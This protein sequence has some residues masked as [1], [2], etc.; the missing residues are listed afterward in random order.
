MDIIS[1]IKSQFPLANASALF[2]ELFKPVLYTNRSGFGANQPTKEQKYNGMHYDVQFYL[3]NS[4][5]FSQTVLTSNLTSNL[6]PINP[7]AIMNLT[8]S[9]NLCNW[10]VGG[11][12][13]LM[14][15]P[16]DAPPKTNT[17]NSRS[18][19]ANKDPLAAYQFR[20]DGLDLLRVMIKPKPLQQSP[21][22][23]SI[24]PNDNRWTLSYMF[25]VFDT[26]DLNHAIPEME[27]AISRFMRCIKLHFR[28]M[29]YDL[30]K[31]TNLEYSTA[32]SPT[33]ETD[34]SLSNGWVQLDGADVPRVTTT[35]I[36]LKEVFE[37]ALL[38]PD[39]KA[40]DGKAKMAKRR[41]DLFI[42]EPQDWD[43]GTSKLFYTSPAG[44]S[45]ID[46]VDYLFS[47]HV[48]TKQLKGGE[49]DTYDMCLL[50]TKR[51]ND[52][53]FL[54]QFC[55]TPISN[56]FEK[57]G[58]GAN[59]PGEL[60]LEHFFVTT[61]GDGDPS[62]TKQF[63]API[64]TDPSS[65]ID[66]K[67]AK[68]GQ[69]ISYSF[70]DMSAE[71]NSTMFATS[72][73]H[74]VDVGKRIFKIH[75]KGN[76]FKTARR[77]LA[78]NYISNLYVDAGDPEKLFLPQQHENKEYL[79]VFPVFSLNG[80]NEIVL[81]RKGLHNLLYTGL[82]QNAC[83]SF[84]TL[85]MS[86]RQPGSFIGIDETQGSENNDYTNK[87]YGQWFVIR[88]DHTFETGCY[89]NQIYAIKM[90]RFKPLKVQM[91]STL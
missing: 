8:I 17:G 81:Q 72:P 84:K 86:L 5:D 55:L 1:I 59:S 78:E 70:V 69:I 58:S 39:S 66:I 19:G 16:N 83:I 30:M 63:K 21:E 62:I 25:S 27:G 85:G 77:V 10:V 79:N 51:P 15:L 49:D 60:Q 31:M 76:D 65:T 36:A 56:F 43:I 82:F 28:D 40:T 12:M 11:S 42:V 90:H 13:V 54:E 29:R 37:Q 3:D 87:L 47:H 73:V 45:A 23:I 35:G 41:D 75:Y 33:A 71:Y 88:V 9:D 91:Q 26:E 74:S 38:D 20:N 32:D 50:H 64:T 34:I 48:S 61:H 80:D 7:S 52:S 89:T 53:N 6:Y 18:S 68:Y 4:G 46:D 44:A 57:A 22:A 14:Y 67:T 2:K 24:S